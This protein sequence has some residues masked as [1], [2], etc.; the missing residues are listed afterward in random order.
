[1][2]PWRKLRQRHHYGGGRGASSL[3]NGVVPTPLEEEIEVLAPMVECR[4]ADAAGGGQGN[5]AAGAVLM[6]RWR[7]LRLWRRRC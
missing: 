7:G 1:M 3:V 6:R 4:G 5:G 2:R